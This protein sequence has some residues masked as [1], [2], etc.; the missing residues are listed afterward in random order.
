MSVQLFWNAS[1]VVTAA[2]TQ[3]ESV[4]TGAAIAVENGHIVE[5]GAAAG[6]SARY[7]RAERH[8]CGGGIVTPGFV[9][10]H[11]HAVFGGYRAAE[12]AMRARGVPYMEIARRGGGINASVRDVR[13]LDEDALHGLAVARLERAVQHGTTTMEIKSGYGLAPDAELKQ[14]R[15]VRSL[16]E[17]GYAVVPTFLGAHEFPPEYRDRRE[18]YVRLVVDEMIPAVARE[19]L[20]VF[21][22]VFCEPGVF[23][24]GQTRTILEAARAH[25]LAGKLHADELEN[26]GGA[27]LAAEL[28]AASADH[29]GAISAAG[30]A[31]LA[32]A[33]DTVATLLPTT[34]LFLG[35][36]QYAPARALIDAGASVALASDYNPGSSPTWNMPLV[37]TIACSQM[38]MDPLEALVAATAGGARALRLADR[39]VLRAGAVADL[40]VWDVADYNE[41]AYHFGA[42]PI[43]AVFRAGRRVR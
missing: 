8:D 25:G 24:P 26:S 9:D 33:P 23:T 11:T 3:P 32:A 20:A 5:L 12:Y 38:R 13:A 41:I 40:I 19:G 21:C 15:V 16:R 39:G 10:S 7:E 14:L 2:G 37:M 18:D 6:L 4:L 27:E 30:V 35:K 31:A 36:S 42:A 22:D 43:R 17:S 28:G 34:L 1:Q 29:L